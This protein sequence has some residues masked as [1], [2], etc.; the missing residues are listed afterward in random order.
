MKKVKEELQAFYHKLSGIMQPYEEYS[1]TPFDIKKMCQE[2]LEAAG[3][4]AFELRVAKAKTETPVYNVEWSAG[5]KKYTQDIVVGLKYDYLL[6]QT[7]VPHE[8]YI[9]N[10]VDDF[11]CK[12]LHSYYLIHCAKDLPGLSKTDVL[13]LI[14]NH[15]LVEVSVQV[16]KHGVIEV[17]E[18][19]VTEKDIQKYVAEHLDDIHVK[20]FDAYGYTDDELKL[21]KGVNI[22][23]DILAE[24]TKDFDDPGHNL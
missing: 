13:N 15:R 20:N 19:Y 17:P 7:Q 4:D 5:A 2:F 23:Q 11:A 10:D 9:G 1:K 16:V 24:E 8:Y 18:Q 22:C 6:K 21:Q 14:H 3:V 12:V